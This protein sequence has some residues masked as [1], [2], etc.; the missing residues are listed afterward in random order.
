MRRSKR[1]DYKKLNETGEKVPVENQDRGTEEVAEISRLLR[2]ISISE[3]DLQISD[4]EDIMDKQK[5]DA[6]MIDESTLLGN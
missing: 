3:E 5:I 4:Q 2:S 1:I 6:L